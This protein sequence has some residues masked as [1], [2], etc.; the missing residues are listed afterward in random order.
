MM[1]SSVSGSIK[2]RDAP[3]PA[4]AGYRRTPF[5]VVIRALVGNPV[6]PFVALIVAGFGVYSAVNYYVA[7]NKGVE[8]FVAT[9][10]E[11][12]IVYVRARGNLSLSER[13]RLLGAIERKVIAI[14]GVESVF[15]FAGEGGLQRGGDGAPKDTVGQIQLELA[16]WGTRRPGAEILADVEEAI[17]AYPGVI[18]EVQQQQ[19]GP[20]QGKPIQLRLQGE[21]WDELMAS[22]QIA[23]DGFAEV[24][25]LT[26]LEDTRPLPGI[27]WEL[28]VDVAT[29]GRF[30]ADVAQIG[31][32]VSLLTNGI[33]LDTMRP[34]GSDEEIEIRVRFPEEFR[35]ISTLDDMRVR[36]AMGMVPLE[37]FVT[38]KPVAKLG[39]INRVDGVRYFDVKADVAPGVNVNEKIAELTA[40][41]EAEAPFP[42]GISWEFTGDQ[43]AQAESQAFLGQAF[44]GALG[45]MFVILLAQFNSV[46]NSIL[47][48]TAVV[49]SVAGVLIGMVVMGQTFSI[50][51]TG[52][53][54]VALAGIVVNNNIVLI[55]TYQEYARQMP[56]IEAIIRTAEQRIRPVLLTTITTMAGLTPMMLSISVDFAAGGYTTGAPAALWWTQLATAVVWGLGTATVL[57]LVVTPAALA[58]RV[59]LGAGVSALGDALARAA[60]PNGP[61][62]TLSRLRR[63]AK[64]AE[65]EPVVW[66][67]PVAAVAGSGPFDDAPE[68]AGN[69]FHDDGTLPRAAE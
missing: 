9:E 43:E 6:M 64:R 12:A 30:G 24:D 42:A 32:M 14:E 27:D 13:D 4:K 35:V 19:D 23:R 60:A 37:N 46:Y 20:Q 58:A 31:P 44:A 59:W 5:G 66:S 67:S 52:T 69:L 36:T 55:D 41:M 65:A 21:D 29:A 50:I 63:A 33:L 56:R 17:G 1:L 48:L 26:E 49:M 11:R 62:A 61:R 16:P 45:L 68:P 25:G 51:M 34:D 10:P 38:R 47:V 8:F 7:N 15:A 2:N 53:G 57:T 40:W 3:P 18:S 39:E 54:I 22:A 28:D